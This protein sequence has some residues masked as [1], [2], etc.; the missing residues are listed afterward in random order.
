MRLVLA[1][2]T[3]T[4]AVTA[5]VVQ[6]SVDVD[7]D[8]GRGTGASRRMDPSQHE[9]RRGHRPVD[10]HRR[11]NSPGQHSFSRT[12]WTGEHHD[13]AGAQPAAQQ[14]TQRHGVIDIRQR[15]DAGLAFSHDAGPD[16]ANGDSAP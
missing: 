1:I 9:R 5:G 14:R 15:R 7:V 11:R 16:R 2:D 4:P 3:S 6:Q 12:E 10:V 13:I 8:H